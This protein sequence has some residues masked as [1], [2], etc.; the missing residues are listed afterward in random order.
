[1]RLVSIPNRKQLAFDIVKTAYRFPFNATIIL[2]ISGQTV[3]ARNLKEI[4]DALATAESIKIKM[5]VA[6]QDME[7]L[8]LDEI[9]S[10]FQTLFKVYGIDCSFYF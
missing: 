8:Y 10:S 5:F 6:E 4:V 1:M 3:D 9:R 2:K 7:V